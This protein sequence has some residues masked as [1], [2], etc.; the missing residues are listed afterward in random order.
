MPRY[1]LVQLGAKSW[2]EYFSRVVVSGSHEESIRMVASGEVDASSVDSM[3]FDYERSVGNPN[4]LQ[5]RIIETLFPGGA[6][7]PPVVMN[8]NADP[9]LREAIQQALVNMYK[10]PAGKRIL[11]KALLLR[12][13]P[14]ND[15]NYDDIRYMESAAHKAGFRDQR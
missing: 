15:A 13:D 12:F 2:E 11:Q 1:K 10:D 6:G 14:P 5:V 8:V 4:A 9:A 3:V 7:A